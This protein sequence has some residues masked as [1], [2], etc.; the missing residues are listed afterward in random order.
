MCSRKSSPGAFLY[1][2]PMERGETFKAMEAG[3]MFKNMVVELGN[4]IS[5]TLLY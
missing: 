2:N 1:N 5:G 3:K 4:I